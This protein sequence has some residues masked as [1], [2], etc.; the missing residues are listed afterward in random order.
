MNREEFLRELRNLLHVSACLYGVW[1]VFGDDQCLEELLGA[2]ELA[3]EAEARRMADAGPL[4]RAFGRYWR[5]N[6]FFPRPVE[7]RELLEPMPLMRIPE[8]VPSACK[9]R[10]LIWREQVEKRRQRE[11]GNE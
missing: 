4:L 2:W 9:C 7:I 11:A 10:V 5:E 1:Q 6:R 3:L 8:P